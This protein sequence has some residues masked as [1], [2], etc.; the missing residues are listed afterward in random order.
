MRY[1]SWFPRILYIR[2]CGVESLHFTF[3]RLFI[4]KN[5][6]GPRQP[7]LVNPHTRLLFRG[8]VPRPFVSLKN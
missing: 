8:K 3:P 5:V 1:R 7:I 6:W 4:D 2:Y